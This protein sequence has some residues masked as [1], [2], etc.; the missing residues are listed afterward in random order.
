LGAIPREVVCSA[1]AEAPAA[2]TFPAAPSIA[3]II[4]T[5]TPTTTAVLRAHLLETTYHGSSDLA[6][7]TFGCLGRRRALLLV[8]FVAVVA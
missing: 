3:P 7:K 1:A 2:S 8:F 5:S 6:G 4:S